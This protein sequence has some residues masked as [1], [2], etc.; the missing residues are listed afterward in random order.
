MD[1]T[2]DKVDLIATTFVLSFR[3]PFM[4]PRA[5]FLS[6]RTFFVTPNEVR[7]P[8]ALTR[9]G[10]TGWGDV[11]PSASEGSLGAC[12]PRDDTLGNVAP[13]RMP[14]NHR[15]MTKEGCLAIA[16]HDIVGVDAS[17][18]LGMT[19]KGCRPEPPSCRPERKRGVSLWMSSQTMRGVPRY[20]SAG[21]SKG[22][23]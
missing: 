8:S 2:R 11:A 17:L 5:F 7:G 3:A 19:G 20:R 21:R 15:L 6:P 18:S 1:G 16:R 23:F 4:S 12:A 10:K 22:L 9:L 13:R 14:R